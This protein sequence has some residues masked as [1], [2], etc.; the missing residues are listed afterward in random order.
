MFS[1]AKRF[2]A[3]LEVSLVSLI[4]TFNVWFHD[5]YYAY[6]KCSIY[7]HYVYPS[8]IMFLALL[9]ILLPRRSFRI[10]GF[11][12]R[13]TIFTL[14]W[15]S[16]FIAVFTLPSLYSIVFS[17]AL[18]ISK[19]A[20]P[21]IHDIIQKVIDYMVFVGFFEEAYFRGYVQSRLNEVY[22]KRWRKLLFKEWSVNY[23]MSLPLTSIIFALVHIVHYWN[24]I[25]SRWNPAWW[26]PI[27]ILGAFAFGCLA[28][29]IREASDIYVSA[30]LHGA[31]MTSYTLLSTYTNV[32]ILN[33]SLFTSWFIFFYILSKYFHE[34]TNLKFK[35]VE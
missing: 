18:G 12:P 26:M 15:C 22:E 21:S 2:L 3:L 24:P 17:I 5:A 6:L 14:K 8:S 28:G 30:S 4:L 7:W 1:L 11:L 35:A 29:A 31:I 32:L 13:N 27:H 10:Y 25:T 34:S 19:S 23:G 16:I 9:A 20:E 33:I